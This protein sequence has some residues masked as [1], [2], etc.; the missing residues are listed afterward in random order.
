[1][2]FSLQSIE[3]IKMCNKKKE[4]KRRKKTCKHE[5]ELIRGALK[6]KKNKSLLLHFYY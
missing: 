1:M 5:L 6:L 2:I 3:K 4:K